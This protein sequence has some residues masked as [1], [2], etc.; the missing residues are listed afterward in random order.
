MFEVA[1]AYEERMGRWS[2][3]LAP[4]SLRS[5]GHGCC[6]LCSLPSAKNLAFP[7]RCA[8]AKET[9]GRRAQPLTISPK[10]RLSVQLEH[11]ERFM[12]DIIRYKVRRILH[13]DRQYSIRS[14][15][16]S[17]WPLKCFLTCS[18]HRL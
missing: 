3:Q 1:E 8:A 4:L 16:T 15:A 17:T 18:A 11:R 13:F 2:R 12:N 10:K 5:T 7:D 9:T 6:C 14:S